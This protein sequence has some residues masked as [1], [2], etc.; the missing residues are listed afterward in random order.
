MKY[1][2]VNADDFGLTRGINEG[3]IRA[4]RDG[5][6]TSATLMATGPAFEHAVELAK[7]NPRLGVG[8]H[9]VLTGGQAVAPRDEI[10]SLVDRNGWLP[11]TL[12]KFVVE[13][14]SGR[15]RTSEIETELRAQLEKLRGAGIEPTH[16]DTHKH[17][18]VHPRVMNALGRV[19][20]EFGITRVRN[21][22]ENLGDSW[23][24]ARSERVS[25]SKNMAAS[26]AVH[27]VAFRFK[28]LSRRYGL[29]S[30]DCFLGL[31]ATGCLGPA[32]LCRLIATVPDGRTEIMVHP[33]IFDADLARL[34][35]RLQ[36]QRQTEM[37]GLLAPEVRR[38][39][40]QYGIQ[41]ITYRELN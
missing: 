23:S 13:V 18:H 3:I 14:S 22:L 35:S 15:L 9:L 25:L 28:A 2:I 6:L 16:V 1:L 29:R 37:E 38:T 5:I 24:T 30:P 4:H 33:G 32:A 10:P 11:K 20:R 34:G 40:E 21:P 12:G 36:Q 27:S 26:V 41:L 39:V 8:C 17:T 31:A 7:A 19:S